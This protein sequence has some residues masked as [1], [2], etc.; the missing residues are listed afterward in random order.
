[1]LSRVSMSERVNSLD[2]S[3]PSSAFSP[4]VHTQY[5]KTTRRHSLNH[6]I[7]IQQFH[8]S[9]DFGSRSPRAC[10]GQWSS[11]THQTR[12]GQRKPAPG[13]PKGDRIDTVCQMLMGLL[14]LCASYCVTF[15]DLFRTYY[16]SRWFE[17]ACVCWC[18][19]TLVSPA[20]VAVRWSKQ[21]VH[22]CFT[23]TRYFNFTD[24]TLKGK[25]MWIFL[26]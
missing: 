20:G 19:C 18:V 24:S 17:L 25:Y 22:Q 4:S 15:S 5:W 26:G 9:F 2:I 3:F 6:T 23:V 21:V 10:Q 14:C 16:N 13:P 7:E 12:R 1:M 8:F 11:D